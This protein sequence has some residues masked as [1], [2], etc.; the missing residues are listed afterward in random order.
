MKCK[1]CASKED[2]GVILFDHLGSISY[3]SK[4]QKCGIQFLSGREKV[5][6]S[7]RIKGG[8]GK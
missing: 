8:K 7:E 2:R 3:F 1:K 5:Y 4:C 6:V